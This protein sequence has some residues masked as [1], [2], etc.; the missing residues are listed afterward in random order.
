[1]A[2]TKSFSLNY[3]D[4]A[5]ALEALKELAK[6]NGWKSALGKGKGD[7]IWMKNT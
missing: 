7:V 6:E 5:T 2:K 3:M 1:M 4:S